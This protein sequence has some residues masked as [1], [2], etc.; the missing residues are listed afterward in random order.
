[1]NT[2]RLA[3]PHAIMLVGI[4]GSGKTFFAEQFSNM[5]KLPFIN[6][7]DVQDQI[8]D[9]T[10]TEKVVLYL[11]SEIMKTEQTFLFEGNSATRTS[12]AEFS[13]WA[14]S[15]GY[16]PLLVWVQTSRDTCMS[17]IAKDRSMATDQF[18]D[19]LEI[20]SAPHPDE[21]AVVISGKHT[22]VSQAKVILEHLG[23]QN[24]ELIKGANDKHLAS[25]SS[26]APDRYGKSN[27]A[28]G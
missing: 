10:N 23:K 6:I 25:R 19:Q 12:R 15:K 13:R 20:F 26:A 16:Q 22:Y 28:M 2:L 27:R 4:P 8:G 1:M 7:A 3:R 24:R 5:F 17:R 21:K 18:E 9:D 14:R 11:L